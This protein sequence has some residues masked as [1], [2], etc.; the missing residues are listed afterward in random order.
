MIG[1]HVRSIATLETKA[2]RTD[3]RLADHDVR[4]AQ[5]ERQ[6]ARIEAAIKANKQVTVT[7]ISLV[8]FALAV[9]QFILRFVG[10]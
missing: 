6:G 5:L 2:D 9:L 10:G 4:L 7:T 3:A 1:A 8:G